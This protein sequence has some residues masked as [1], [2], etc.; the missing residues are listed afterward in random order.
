MQVRSYLCQ[1]RNM[2]S[3]ETW[4]AFTDVTH[5]CSNKS[6]WYSCGIH[7]IAFSPAVCLYYVQ[8][9]M[10]RVLP[11]LLREFLVSQRTGQFNLVNWLQ[12][13]FLSIWLHVLWYGLKPAYDRHLYRNG[14]PLLNMI[15]LM[16]TIIY[17][18]FIK[19]KLEFYMAL[20]ICFIWWEAVPPH[21]SGEQICSA[22]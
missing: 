16:N 20:Q 5:T 15:Q 12:K 21:S 13:S 1:V 8:T 9:Y 7:E 6:G 2:L 14:I 18:I 4:L 10:Y 11:L 19:F 3:F 22:M 17:N